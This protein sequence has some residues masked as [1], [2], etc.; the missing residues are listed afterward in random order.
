MEH[1]PGIGEICNKNVFK[2]A[3][4]AT[5]TRLG[6]DSVDLTHTHTI[7]HPCASGCGICFIDIVVIV[8][9]GLVCPVSPHSP[10]Y[11]DWH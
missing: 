7:N 5:T 2:Q 4:L 9:H 11:P 3:K 6:L 1:D 8:L 10:Q